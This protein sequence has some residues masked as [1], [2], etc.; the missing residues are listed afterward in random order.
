MQ[1]KAD[2]NNA[3]V[4]ET[5]RLLLK[6]PSREEDAGL[7]GLWRDAEVRRYLGG[8][9]GE[10]VIEK[11]LAWQQTHWQQ[12]GFGRWTVYEKASGQ[13]AGLCGLHY[14]QKGIELSYDFY[15]IFWRRGIAM[16]AARACLEDGF[17]RLN[18][19][20]VLIITQEAN[21]ASCRLAEKLG[22]HKIERL[23]EFESWQSVYEMTRE[24][25]MAPEEQ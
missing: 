16:E 3:E 12:A 6:R 10:E 21:I 18:I 8:V 23:W 13:I 5:E 1:N 20:S 19:E 17:S 7:S 11:K 4:L 9:V 25:F 14:S 22:M 2:V 15:P 24:A